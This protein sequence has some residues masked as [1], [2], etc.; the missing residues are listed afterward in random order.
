MPEDKASFLANE[1]G[2]ITEWFR[3]ARLVN[4]R[5]AFAIRMSI[6]LLSGA[7]TV[8][9]GF[10]G[11]ATAAVIPM[12]NAALALSALVSL[13]ATWEGF[14]S[15]RA[16]WV[17]YTATLAR[18]QALRADLQYNMLR[19]QSESQDSSLNALQERLNAIL[20]E[21][22]TFWVGMRKDDVLK[23]KISK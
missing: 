10:Q 11:V 21:T 2:R 9:L 5:K 13:L 18:L 16:L 17:Q 6:T 3:R 22:N 1:I 7:T 20:E 4:K 12:K 8:V 14:F 19:P 15:H 23:D